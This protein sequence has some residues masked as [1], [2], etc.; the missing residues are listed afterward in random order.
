MVAPVR[1]DGVEGGLEL[2][3]VVTA[4]LAGAQVAGDVDDVAAVGGDVGDRARHGDEDRLVDAEHVGK[5]CDG[6]RPH[7]DVEVGHAHRHGRA[8][9]VAETRRGV[10]RQQAGGA[11]WHR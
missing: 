7:R 10:A 3:P 1:L 6:Q 11:A 5:R 2:R 9:D 4:L 8:G